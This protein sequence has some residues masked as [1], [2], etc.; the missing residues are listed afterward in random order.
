MLKIGRIFGLAV[1][2]GIASW[3]VSQP[4]G[5][6]GGPVGPGF[7]GFFGG[8]PPGREE[9]KLVKEFD[10]NDDGWLN[11]EE[12]D[13]ARKS[14]ADR[15]RRGSPGFGPPGDRGPQEGRPPDAD[16]RGGGPEGDND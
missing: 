8:G 12:R 7:G 11:R 3:A 5:G 13:A 15:P 4:P 1:V 14:L 9:I 2:L 10:T 16:R 6:P